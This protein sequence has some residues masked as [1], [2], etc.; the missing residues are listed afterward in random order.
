MSSVF[1]AVAAVALVSTAA[2][3]FTSCP[4]RALRWLSLSLFA[5]AVLA[6]VAGPPIA[7]IASAALPV[8]ALALASRLPE[9]TAV[10]ARERR[11]LTPRAW[12]VPATLTLLVL[13]G[14]VH[15]LW[16]NVGL[17]LF[18]VVALADLPL[19]YGLSLASVQFALGLLTVLVRRNIVFMLMG[20]V[21][22]LS[23]AG[24]A[25]VLGGARWEPAD[26]QTLFVLAPLVAIAVAAVG[27]G[28]A[29]RVVR[30]WGRFD[31]A[32]LPG[33]RR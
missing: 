14:L 25:L 27:A 8:V 21:I 22:M 18:P 32:A 17:G 1:L 4:V 5:G 12:V 13:A 7:A 26:G 33:L 10:A 23:A 24:V 3:V 30:R 2:V 19:A 11:W 29:R 28:F 31:P 15:V 16:S 6:Y 20:L 9:A